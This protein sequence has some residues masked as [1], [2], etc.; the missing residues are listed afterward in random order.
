MAQYVVETVTVQKRERLVKINWLNADPKEIAKVGG[1]RRERFQKDADARLKRAMGGYTDP[2]RCIVAARR[3]ALDAT[4][5]DDDWMLGVT[6]QDPL[7]FFYLLACIEDDMRE[8]QE[9][10]LVRNGV[11]PERASQRGNRCILDTE[12]MLHMVLQHMWTGCAQ[13]ALQGPFGVDQSTVSRTIAR[14]RGTLARSANVPTDKVITKEIASLPKDAAIKATGGAINA[15]FTHIEI[16]APQDQKS[17]DKAY[18]GKAHTTTCNTMF[19]CLDNGLIISRS[20]PVGGRTSE[21]EILRREAPDLGHVTESL[22]NPD[23]PEGERIEVRVDKGPRGI[24]SEWP[25]ANVSMP[26]FK[27]RGGELTDE[28]RQENYEMNSKRA[29]IENCFADI[30]DYRLVKNVFRGS[31]DDLDE[32]LTVLTGLTNLAKVMRKMPGWKP[33]THLKKKKRGRKK[34]GPKGRKPLLTF[35]KKQ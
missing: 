6:G 29:K 9:A 1:E 5:L 25:G 28:Q 15:D 24:R 10:P 31:V 17:N 12:H 4:L 30:K 34:A 26:H 11:D 33:K 22:K 16:E 7:R 32:T 8:D 23:T 18:S 19:E 27:P 14:I 20:C 13:D 35:K 2:K 3:V 21:I